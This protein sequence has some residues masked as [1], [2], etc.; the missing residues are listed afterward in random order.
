MS[1]VSMLEKVTTAYMEPLI[2]GDAD[3]TYIERSYEGNLYRCEGC[4]RCWDKKWYAETCA[5]RRHVDSFPQHYGW[6]Q[7]GNGR[8]VPTTT[9]TRRAL[10]RDKVGG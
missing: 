6:K 8:W 1:K 5:D 9:Y 3:V 7:L 10:R 2:S 4:G